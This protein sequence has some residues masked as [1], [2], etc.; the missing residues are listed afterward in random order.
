[1]FLFNFYILISTGLYSSPHCL[2]RIYIFLSC[3]KDSHRAYLPSLPVVQNT[4]LANFIMYYVRMCSAGIVQK[5]PSAVA[6][7]SS[8]S[9]LLLVLMDVGQDQVVTLRHELGLG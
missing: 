6:H 4:F 8:S 2:I 5:G 9:S 3:C 7:T 1:M